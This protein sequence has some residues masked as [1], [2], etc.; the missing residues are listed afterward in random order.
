LIAMLHFSEGIEKRFHKTWYHSVEDPEQEY[1][2][3]P[4]I[5]TSNL[6]LCE[7]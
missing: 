2:Y 6:T 3:N 4:V 5:S 7:E 1:L